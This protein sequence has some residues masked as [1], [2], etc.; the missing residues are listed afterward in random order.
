IGDHGFT[1]SHSAG[2]VE[3]VGGAIKGTESE[4]YHVPPVN[5]VATITIRIFARS[6]VGSGPDAMHN[7]VRVDPLNEIAEINENNNTAVQHTVV[8]TGGAGSGAFNQLTISK[9]QVSPPNPVARNAKV[10]Y[11]ITVGNDA[12][13]PVTG[14]KV[15]DFLPAGAHYIQATGSLGS[16]FLCT[17]LANFVDC[18]GGT[19]A[20]GGSV[21]I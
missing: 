3:C 13:D 7:E 4:F 12:T 18:N 11:L 6:F 16:Q 1:C 20:A 2:V 14:V 19:I 21:T 15:R 8:S 10:T 17:Q 5:D 9:V